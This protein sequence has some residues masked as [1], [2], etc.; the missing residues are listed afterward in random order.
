MIL[1]VIKFIEDE[2]CSKKPQR[3]TKNSAG[4]DIFSNSD[5]IL[6]SKEIN[7]VTISQRIEFN[8]DLYRVM[9]F[10]RSSFGIKKNIRL[11]NVPEERIFKAIEVLPGQEIKANLLNIGDED[12]NLSEGEHFVQLIAVDKDE[13]RRPFSIEAVKDLKG[14]IPIQVSI[15]DYSDDDKSIVLEEQLKLKPGE[16]V[17]VPS[18]FK[19]RIEEDTFLCAAVPEDE[20]RFGL[21]NSAAIID[22]D[23]YNN[24]ANEGQMFFKIE[25]RT[26]RSLTL[27]VGTTLVDMISVRYYRA[28]NGLESDVERSGGIGST[29]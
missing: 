13:I 10:L 25:N 11:Y 15:A 19:A 23:Y 16:S 21:A 27:P 6:K 29:S 18:G 28:E 2:K 7:T 20:K 14:V 4:Y 12:V 1:L 17:M 3:A 26:L 5:V 22:S 9:L 8:A 24:T